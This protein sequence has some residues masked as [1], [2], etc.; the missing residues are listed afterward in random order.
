MS[1]SKRITPAALRAGPVG[2]HTITARFR[3][4]LVAAL[5]GL[6]ALLPAHPALAAGSGSITGTLTDAGAPV[7]GAT[8]SLLLNVYP[9]SIATTVT[10]ADGAFRLDGVAAGTYKVK[11]S[12]PGGLE[13]F[14][15]GRAD[16]A[17]GASVTV[18]DGQSVSV[19]D[20]VIAH[21]SLAGRIT[22][23]SGAPAARALVGITRPAAAETAHV[24]TDDN[25]GYLLP[26]VPAG[27]YREFVSAAERAAPRQWVHG[28]KQATDADP[29]VVALGQRTTVDEALLPLGTISGHYTD[30]AGRPVVAPTVTAYSQSSAAESVSTSATADGGFRMIAYPGTYKL[31][32][33]APA[34][35][36]LDQWAHGKE[37]ERTADVIT[38]T[39][40]TDTVLTERQ[41]PTGRIS[42]R[43][44]DAAG[45]PV[46][47]AAVAVADPVRDR[48]FVAT[49]AADGSWFLLAW[50]GS[51]R[52]GYSTETQ[53]QWAHGAAT[54]DG[55][56][57]AAVTDG[58][59]TVVDDALTVP[60][61]LT[62]TAVDAQTGR[63][64]SSFCAET[65]GPYVY[66]PQICT[67][68]GTVAFPA[69]GAG[70]VNVKVTDGTHLDG[71]VPVRV[72]AGRAAAVTARLGAGATVNLTLVDA[73]TGAP[74]DG[75][76][77]LVPAARI[78]SPF[79]GYAGDCSTD[80]RITVARVRPEPYLVFARPFDAALGAQWVGPH[81]GVGARAAALVITP[82]PGGTVAVGVRFDAATTITGT[83][84]DR[85]TGA[86]VTGAT[87][88]TYVTEASTDAAGHYTVDGL[89]PYRWTLVYAQP[90]Y[91]G[92]LS[93]R[94]DVALSRGTTV[95][96]RLSGEFGG[97]PESATVSVVDVRTLDVLAPSR[98][99]RT[100]ATPPGYSRRSRYG[101]SCSTP[102]T[103]ARTACSA[104]TP[105]Y[106]ARP[107]WT[108]PSRSTAACDRTDRPPA[109][110]GRSA[111][112]P[113][114]T[115]AT[116]A[117]AVNPT[118]SHPAGDARAGRPAVPDGRCGPRAGR[119]LLPE[120]DPDRAALVDDLAG[121]LPG[122][123]VEVEGSGVGGDR[124][125]Q[126]VLRTALAVGQS[127]LV[128]IDDVAAAV[129]VDGVESGDRVVAVGRGVAHL[130]GPGVLVHADL[131]A[132]G[133]GGG[134]R[135]G[136]LCRSTQDSGAA[137]DG[138]QDD[139]GSSEVAPE[140]FHRTSGFMG[141][142][143]LPCGGPSRGPVC[144]RAQRSDCWANSVAG[145]PAD[146][147]GSATR[148][149]PDAPGGRA[150][151]GTRGKRRPGRSARS[152]GPA[153][154]RC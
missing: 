51:Y 79:E 138:G 151:P 30:T 125:R 47:S 124:G 22:T 84:T 68:N 56:I 41:L 144:A 140:R 74:V 21:G 148:R 20:T 110:G 35:A 128:V 137:C 101:W 1:V 5:V 149:S 98:R 92:Q 91:A 44:T 71:T 96:G 3:R 114:A 132:G 108:S 105:Q 121:A 145:D 4:L 40:G 115:R 39:A 82:G 150:A 26:Y 13:Q 129:G 28:H 104:G 61:S 122:L 119:A 103:P 143:M 2:P 38:V 53:A 69:V 95:T 29:V 147:A 19:T 77:N 16:F 46:A 49:T 72:V 60:G 154:H 15:P 127:T 50:A 141:A 133:A 11:F 14:Y 23:A 134:T 90:A 152:L 83:V 100:A 102:C 75:C 131:A 106:A 118:H 70:T 66:L 87:V 73:V 25:G 36:G 130:E 67:D 52:V 27:S 62:V 12:L 126:Q 120:V 63:R 89:G 37:S 45:N 111:G 24:L 116:A 7:P 34:G 17:S 81:G 8:V 48:Q 142:P 97:T 112:T 43:L 113:R 153:V 64:L 117:E 59:N 57:R 139:Q 42:G 107:G 135:V 78:P 10:G 31:K 65:S 80:G 85:V 33:T 109:S 88:G 86:P 136:C 99:P 146:R 94:A 6:L 9:V 55:A 58:G 93:S 54:P 123:G 76:V 18:A 32:F